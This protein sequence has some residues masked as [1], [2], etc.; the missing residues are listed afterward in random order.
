[1]DITPV[2]IVKEVSYQD[3]YEMW[4]DA[5]TSEG[6]ASSNNPWI[7][8]AYSKYRTNN[9]PSKSKLIDVMSKI[10]SSIKPLVIF[11]HPD[12]LHVP[13]SKDEII[14]MVSLGML[15]N[16]DLAK[17]YYN[18]SPFI[19]TERKLTITNLIKSIYTFIK[20]KKEMEGDRNYFW[21]KA[22][23]E[24]YTLA[25]KLMPWDVYYV[26]KMGNAS[27]TLFERSMFWL[28][29]IYTLTKGNRSVKMLLWLQ[30]KDMKMEKTIK[31]FKIN[32][33]ELVKNYFYY[34]QNHPFI[35]G[36]KK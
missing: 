7:Y 24:T 34:D 22:L 2:A 23:T 11:R 29:L 17:N 27:P 10:L 36:L 6:R 20:Y 30:L 19:G 4:H 1:M 5:P 15:S 33:D 18:F 28:N 25:F 8:T 16:E 3:R 21:E 13:I 31:F 12:R 14:G 26:K 35:K 32:E 9:T